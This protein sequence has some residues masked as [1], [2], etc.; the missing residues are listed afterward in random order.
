MLLM[1]GPYSGRWQVWVKAGHCRWK[2]ATL[3]LCWKLV[4][5]QANTYEPLGFF[6][7]STASRVGKLSLSHRILPSDAC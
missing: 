7:Q 6:L 4:M 3:T 1:P 2:Q 5:R